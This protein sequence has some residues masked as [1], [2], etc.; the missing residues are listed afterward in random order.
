MKTTRQFI[1]LFVLA[2]WPTAG[3]SIAQHSSGG[4]E[5]IVAAPVKPARAPYAGVKKRICIAKFDA[6]SS[7]A[8]NFMGADIGGG[9]SAQLTTALVES[10]RFLVLERASLAEIQREQQLGAQR[11][12]V[13]E[14]ASPSA[15][16]GVDT[17]VNAPL[18]TGALPY[19]A[20]GPIAFGS[21]AP[22]VGAPTGRL[23]D[24]QMLI[25]GSVTEFEQAAKG[26]G[27]SIGVG[28][29]FS[30]ASMGRKVVEGHLG[31]DIR[32]IDTTTGQVLVSKH[33]EARVPESNVSVTLNVRDVNFGG[34]NF[35]KT[36]LGKA[37]R[38]AIEKAVDLII[39][40]MEVVPWTGRVADLM[41]NQVLVNA[42]KD[43]GLQ[44]GMIF[45][46]SSI[47]KEVIDP[48]SGVSL[49]VIEAPRGEIKVEQVQE[50]F[51]IASLVAGTL[52]KKGDLLR[53]KK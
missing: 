13:Q 50:K 8:S 46:V 18:A 31:M 32:L 12:A 48:A 25:A 33:V 37:T 2:A 40:E 24:A 29:M 45:T 35:K 39:Q 51:S 43:M 27:M 42:G 16:P 44:P 15:A 26:G 10:G 6:V 34:E 19:A 30:G 36:P 22:E 17:T 41:E 38:E 52:P 53:L 28:G 9:V 23:I 14:T 11:L 21:T 47:V 49:G 5:K 1:S 7:V 3:Y 4:H 20:P